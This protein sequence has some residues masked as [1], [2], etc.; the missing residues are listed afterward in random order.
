M[1]LVCF[2]RV[3]ILNRSKIRLVW[4][5]WYVITFLWGASSTRCE[6]TEG[7]SLKIVHAAIASMHA[8]RDARALGWG[9]GGPSLS[10][11]PKVA[12][13]PV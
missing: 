9:W 2:M 5:R 10:D 8:K 6:Q 3:S 4:Q 12:V 1:M 13:G 7:R 11:H